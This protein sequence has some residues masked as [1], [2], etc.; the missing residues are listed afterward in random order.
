MATM[1]T[2]LWTTE[3]QTEMYRFFSVAFNAAPGT[4]YMDQLYDA[5]ISGMSTKEIVNAFVTK[6]EFTS[7]YPRS[8]ANASFATKIVDNVVGSSAS[9]TAKAAAV[10]DITAA[11]TAGMSRGD[12]VY[13]IFTNLANKPATDADWAGTAKQ[14]AN[15]VEV[16]KYYTETLNSSGTDLATLRKVVAG[17]T[18]QTDTSSPA[19]LAAVITTAL[20]PAP[21]TFLLT[22]GADT[23]MVGGDGND[24]FNSVIGADGA[25]T[26]GTTLNA[27]DNLTGGAG[28]D[29]LNVSISGGNTQATITTSAVSLTGIENLSISNFQTAT[30]VNSISLALA[31]G[32]QKVALSATSATGDTQL[33]SVGAV[34]QAEMAN[35]AGDLDLG[36]SSTAIVGTADTQVLNLRGQT[37][38][39]F[40]VNGIETLAINSAGSSNTLKVSDSGS[41]STIATIKVTGDKNL[42]L[43]E[44]ITN[45]ISKVD[46]SAFTGKLSFTTDD[47]TSISITGG[48]ADDT[49]D[50]GVT[51][52]SADTIDG[53][54]GN[55]TLTVANTTALSATDFKNISNVET[56][57]LTG[58]VTASL[59]ANV[60]PTTFDLNNTTAVAQ[61]LTFAS[62]YT[63][64][65]TVKVD[66]L[67][68]VVNSAN[69]TL[70]IQGSDAAV[71]LITLTGGTGSDTLQITGTKNSTNPTVD[72]A[73]N[74]VITGV[75]T[76][77]IADAGD[78]ATTGGFDIA[79]DLG[80]YATAVTID[81]TALDAADATLGITAESLT[82]YGSAATKAMSVLGGGGGDTIVGGTLNDTL[83]GNG[84]ADSIVGSAGGD[85]SISGGDGDDIIDM[86]GA[87]TVGD[88]IDGGAGNDT[89]KITSLSQPTAL[90]NVTNVEKIALSGANSSL[91]L[92]S[93]LAINTVDMDLGTSE[94]TAQTLTLSSGYTSAVTVYVDGGDKVDNSGA[95]VA[96][97]VFADAAQLTSAKATTLTG[98]TGT[99][100]LSVLADSATANTVTTSNLVT[101]FDA[102]V[103]RDNGDATTGST[104]LAGYDVTIDLTSY[105][106]AS[107]TSRLSVDASALDGLI[108]TDALTAEVLTITGASNRALAVTGGGSADVIV[109]SASTALGDS[110]VGGGGDDLF[111]MGAN[112]TYVDTISG[113]DGKDTVSL[114]AAASDIQFINVTSVETLDLA[115]YASGGASTLG[116]YASAAGIAAVTGSSSADVIN[117]SGMTTAV[118]I[119][120]GAGADS[121]V[122]GTA[123]DTFSSRGT[124][125]DA[126]DT[127]TGG[128]GTDTISLTNTASGLTTGQA[129]SAVL[130]TVTTVEQVVVVDSATDNSAGDVSITFDMA[131]A[132]TGILIDGSALDMGT[133]GAQETLTVD[134]SLNSSTEK[135]TVLGGA[136]NDTISGGN[137]ADSIN[138]GAG[139]DVIYGGAGAD[140]LTGGSGNDLF[141]LNLSTDTG[142]IS[143]SVLGAGLPLISGTSISTIG[144]DKIMDFAVGDTIRTNISG[145][146]TAANL[147]LSSNIDAIWNSLEGLVKGNYDA[148]S[149]AF[150]VSAT[151]TSAMYI[152]DGDGSSGGLL[153]GI[154]L[155]GYAQTL[156]QVS[157]GVTGLIGTSG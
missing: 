97:T 122:G 149:N 37:A 41:S 3:R 111:T 108:G 64:T 136:G 96:L 151:G 135:V 56:L 33:T 36:Y 34:V 5:V 79:L 13:Q 150:V 58:A 16:A 155:V 125:L 107:G 84:G 126:T 75:D 4:T 153:Y 95:A 89:L 26:N 91:S 35:G 92:A 138:A 42:T 88:T 121:I 78:G 140:I 99:D 129:T 69:T 120:S 51:Y 131:Y 29:T 59:A 80:A 98:G 82:V 87:L 61:S 31:T 66:S 18:D 118:T 86:G 15:Q 43:T 101:S 49:F 110:L 113:G 11:L 73:A 123:S 53:G 46:A 52:S 156:S 104:G 44:G 90:T 6:T 112:L 48:S 141:V 23:T 19:A 65:S 50:L 63:A 148:T 17:V 147:T 47:A 30:S 1:N 154:V 71:A 119:T 132:Q 152:F 106:T 85:D 117:A 27:G 28:T 55:D 137:A 83:V 40:K 14:M 72:F 93:N 128:A 25:A 24:T 139:D 76:V 68:S 60:V 157:S 127:I 74:G 114:T 145:Q 116:A 20:P 7:V 67:D 2:A 100:T 77:V 94:N 8:M 70:T 22:S 62:G 10:A 115:G 103:V 45:K 54:L 133:G 142:A 39:E 144:M 38:G 57:K 81:A 32:L 12:I 109:G 102:I 105:G 134:A 130:K 143:G 9:A 124:D 146:G 21:L